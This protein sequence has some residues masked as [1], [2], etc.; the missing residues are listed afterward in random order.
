MKDE[1]RLFCLQTAAE[2]LELSWEVYYDPTGVHTTH[3]YGEMEVLKMGR[4]VSTSISSF[5]SMMSLDANLDTGLSSTAPVDDVDDVYG[6]GIGGGL[7][8]HAVFLLWVRPRQPWNIA[9]WG[10][11]RRRE[12]WVKVVVTL[13]RLLRRTL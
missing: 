11:R 4:P 10:R 6:G 5:A 9:V 1:D 3:G 2:M 13:L 8:R 12:I 7:T